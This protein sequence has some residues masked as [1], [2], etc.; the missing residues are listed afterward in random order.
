MKLKI[1][2]QEK[3]EK[4]QQQSV[5]FYS[6]S[7]DILC[8]F[9]DLVVFQTLPLTLKN[10]KPTHP[11]T[12]LLARAHTTHYTLHTHTLHTHTHTHYTHTSP[13]SFLF[14]L[15]SPSL[16]L[17]ICHSS[18]PPHQFFPSSRI[19]F[20]RWSGQSRD[21]ERAPSTGQSARA[22]AE[23]YRAPAKSRSGSTCDPCWS[24]RSQLSH[25]KEYQ[26]RP[27]ARSC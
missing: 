6:L 9:L 7:F 12:N 16:L 24:S 23:C 1:K 10:P 11:P 22:P 14:P 18:P 21:S 15:L 2:K 19:R 3:S 25:R 13:P 27:S 8:L 17:L 5:F 26:S 20:P 4:Q